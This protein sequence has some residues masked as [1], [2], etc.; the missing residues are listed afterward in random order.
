[1]MSMHILVS[2]ATKHFVMTYT[3]LATVFEK[4]EQ[5][6]TTAYT[7]MQ[8]VKLET[9]PPDRWLQYQMIGGGILALFV[10]LIFVRI[11]RGQR[12]KKLG[13]RIENED[14]GVST[15]DH[16][17]YEATSSISAISAVAEDDHDDAYDMPETREAPAPRKAERPA[18]PAPVAKK[19][20]PAPAPTPKVQAPAPAA[21]KPS[22]PVAPKPAAPAVPAPAPKVEVRARQKTVS[23]EVAKVEVADEVSASDTPI[24]GTWNLDESGSHHHDESDFETSGVS[25]IKTKPKTV[26]APAT[27]SKHQKAPAPRMEV[28]DSDDDVSKVARLSEIL[29]NTGDTKKKKK[30]FFGWGKSKDKDEDDKIENNGDDNQEIDGDD[31]WD[32]KSKKKTK[33]AP[34]KA[35]AQPK[36][37]MKGSSSVAAAQPVSQVS[38]IADGGWNLAEGHADHDAD[39]EED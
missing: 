2:S 20:A 1:M 22:A 32:S 5:G 9:S 18:A 30:G 39:D 37:Q 11:V 35:K 6:L 8:S 7:A 38:E 17:D 27:K 15:D 26:I 31:D 16:D 25:E 24:S 13:E 36:Q 14:G 33:E 34:V 12:M 23:S 4:Q 21:K 29:P 28:D 19:A 3:D 10:L